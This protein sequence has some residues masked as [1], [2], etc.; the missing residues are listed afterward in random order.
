M[1]VAEDRVAC[2]ARANV[3]ET[4][5]LNFPMS[6]KLIAHQVNKI[7]SSAI[8][9]VTFRRTYNELKSEGV[10]SVDNFLALMSRYFIYMMYVYNPFPII[11]RFVLFNFFIII[12]FK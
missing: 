10:T 11:S 6:S 4:N 8:D 3:L 7:E 1:G 5:I 2:Q 9:P 12:I